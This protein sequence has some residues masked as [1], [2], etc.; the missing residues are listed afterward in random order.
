MT[1]ILSN[2]GNLHNKAAK[3]TRL[4]IDM[5][6]MVDLGFLLITFFVFSA[7]LIKPTAMKLFMPSEKGSATPAPESSTI[8]LILGKEGRLLCY[9]GFAKNNNGYEVIDLNARSE[10]LRKRINTKIQTIKNLH[11]A[12]ALITV[13]IKPDAA[14]NYKMLVAT[15]DEMTIN[16]VKK[17]AIADLDSDDLELMTAAHLR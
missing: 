2:T 14:S 12:D 15:L 10:Q 5:T 13:I 7:M 1:E 4:N 17:Y 8:T 3:R 9:D 6:P 16:E 11:G